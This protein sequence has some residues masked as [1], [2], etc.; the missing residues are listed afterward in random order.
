MTRVGADGTTALES[1][2]E[3]NHESF[4][5]ENGPEEEGGGSTYQIRDVTRGVLHSKTPPYDMIPP[6]HDRK[7]QQI[8][9]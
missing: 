5:S 2:E 1:Y 8:W 9:W 6:C 3:A 7:T 4:G